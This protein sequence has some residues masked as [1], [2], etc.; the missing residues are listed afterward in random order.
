MFSADRSTASLSSPCSLPMRPRSGGVSLRRRADTTTAP[1]NATLQT[2]SPLTG[3]DTEVKHARH[4]AL[5]RRRGS[6]DWRWLPGL[7]LAPRAPGRDRWNG[8]PRVARAL[9]RF[10]GL[11]RSACCC[12]H[13]RS[14]HEHPGVAQATAG[15]CCDLLVR[16]HV[17]REVMKVDPPCP[18]RK[19][20]L[21]RPERRLR[22]PAMPISD[23]GKQRPTSAYSDCCVLTLRSPT[24]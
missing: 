17:T 20:H 1:Q 3:T 12:E 5:F 18:Y 8:W 19:V 7:A 11:V 13:E 23:S 22:I 24:L 14:S 21:V 10:D 2:R 9:F 15:R 4:N 16:S 6:G